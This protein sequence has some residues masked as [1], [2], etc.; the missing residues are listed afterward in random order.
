MRTLNIHY[1]RRSINRLCDFLDAEYNINCGGCCFVAYEIAK[2]LDRLGLKYTLKIYDNC[3]KD[4]SAINTEVRKKR[5]NNS[6]RESVVG[7]YSCAHYFLWLEGAGSI[8]NA[9]CFTDWGTYS[10]SNINHTHIRWI[11]RVSVWNDIYDTSN[12][13]KIKKII[14]S[15]FKSYEQVSRS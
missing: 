10:I 11:Y 8:N 14:N 4:L 5:K 12:N 3:G 7:D 13:S 2:H 15:Y 6:D 1:L 9:N